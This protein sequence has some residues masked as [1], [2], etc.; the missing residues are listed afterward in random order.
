MRAQYP[1]DTEAPVPAGVPNRLPA[2]GENPN[3]CDS[4]RSRLRP[5]I[6]TRLI[7]RKRPVKSSAKPFAQARRAAGVAPKNGAGSR[8]EHSMLISGTRTEVPARSVQERLAG[9]PVVAPRNTTLSILRSQR[10]APS[11]IAT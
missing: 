5:P 3:G 6:G 11:G 10:L 8:L 4:T 9:P 1:S 7:V 2:T